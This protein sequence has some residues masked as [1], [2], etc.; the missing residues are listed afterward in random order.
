MYQD[1]SL[2]RQKFLDR[3]TVAQLISFYYFAAVSVIAL[4]LAL[5][6]SQKGGVNLSFIDVLF[7]AVSAVSVTGL[8]SV[9]TA[10]SFSLFGVFVLLIAFHIG[11]LGVMAIGTLIWLALGRKIGFKERRMIMTDQNTRSISGIVRLVKGMLGVILMIELIGFLILGTYY[12]TYFDSTFDAYLNGLFS[13]IS[14]TTNSGFDITGSSL[15]MFYDDY[16]VQFIHI[17]LIISGA[18]GFPVLI[19]L[20]EYLKTKAEQR[21]LQ[22]FSLFTKLTT[23]TYLILLVFAFVLLLLFESKHY[24]D[25]RSWHEAIFNSLF[26]ATTVRSAGLSTLDINQF[27]EQSQILLSTMM[28]IGASPSSVGGGIRT[29]TF[30]LVII[31]ILTFA[32]GQTSVKI[33]RREI[34]EEDLFKAVVVTFLAIILFITSVITITAIEP[35]SLNSIIFE[36]SSAF[37]TCGLSMG[38]TPDLSSFSKIILMAL[39]FI[40]RIGLLT[41]LLSFNKERSKS[42]FRYPKEKINIG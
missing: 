34:E 14:A 24:F 33:F 17:L 26:Q 22:R 6:I 19:E 25:G 2:K 7:T 4:L 20:K 8:T 37:G 40:G 5:P 11:G 9:S 32:R 27:T 3:F 42:N 39:M 36:V 18:I 10:D 23:L 12:L 31:F 15:Y 41:F 16:F 21:P 30:A 29:T 35:F 38:I 28:F 13:A 1:K